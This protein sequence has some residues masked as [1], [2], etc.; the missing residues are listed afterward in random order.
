MSGSQY[1]VNKTSPCPVCP[2]ERYIRKKD[3]MKFSRSFLE[4]FVFMKSENTD[5]EVIIWDA[6]YLSP[7]NLKLLS[8]LSLVKYS[9]L[10]EMPKSKFIYSKSSVKEGYS[11][12]GTVCNAGGF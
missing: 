6:E 7:P 5:K 8:G 1:A 10:C 2:A 4:G 3:C 9:M 12:T 11:K